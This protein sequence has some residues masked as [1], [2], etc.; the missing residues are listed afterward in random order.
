MTAAS[1]VAQPQAQSADLDAFEKLASKYHS[2]IALPKF[3]T[4]SNAVFASVEQIIKSGDKALDTIGALK[5]NQISFKTTVVALDDIG[6]EIG[7]TANRLSLIKETSTNTLV[8]EAATDAIKQLEEWMVGLDYREDVYRTLKAFAATKPNL[9]GED[10]KLFQETMR[11]YRRAGLE[12]PKTERDQVEKMRKELSR[13]T[14]DYESNITK[15]QQAV[16]FTKAELEGVPEDFLGQTG[17]T[18]R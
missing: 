9:K 12:L 2:I 10:A 17:S 1:T 11:D 16:K 4:T 18:Y 13:L 3:E 7:L 15:A 14:T 8:R 6:Y 5:P